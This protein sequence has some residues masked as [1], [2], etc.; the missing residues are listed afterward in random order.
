MQFA[1][2]V[3]GSGRRAPISPF[4]VRAPCRRS[5]NASGETRVGAAGAQP[6]PPRPGIAEEVT[7][8]TRQ[9]S[10]A[11]LGQR[12]TYTDKRATGVAKA[13]SSLQRF[14]A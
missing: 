9:T 4:V 2:G 12:Q 1:P 7:F 8:W 14:A 5:A 11:T 3:E 13:C 10:P 6:V